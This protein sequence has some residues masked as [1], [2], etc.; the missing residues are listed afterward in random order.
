MD[1]RDRISSD[2]RILVGKPVIKGTRLAV[3]HILGLVASGWS[4]AQLM[5]SYPGLQEDDIRACLE[6]Q[7]TA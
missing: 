4:N 5:S 3:E 6:H 7:R 1:W 2:A